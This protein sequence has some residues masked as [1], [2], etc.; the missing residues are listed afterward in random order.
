MTDLEYLVV[1]LILLG[2]AL[3]IGLII[4]TDPESEQIR[5]SQEDI[6]NRVRLRRCDKDPSKSKCVTYKFTGNHIGIDFIAIQECECAR[7]KI[8]KQTEAGMKIF[9]KGG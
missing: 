7:E 8:R 5:R 4:Y 3:F 9:F 2:V 6:E 1:A